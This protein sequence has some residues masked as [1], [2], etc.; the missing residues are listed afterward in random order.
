M[1]G[2][3]DVK[4]IGDLR[5][6]DHLCCLFETEEEHRA[7]VTPYILQGLERGEILQ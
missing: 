4:N 5:P 2:V 6:G 3:H 7:L 1:S